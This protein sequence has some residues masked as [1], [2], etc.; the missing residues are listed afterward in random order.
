MYNVIFYKLCIAIVNVIISFKEAHK[1]NPE[2]QLTL[3]VPVLQL[4]CHSHNRILKPGEIM[5]FLYLSD[6]NIWTCGHSHTQFKLWK[7]EIHCN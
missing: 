3:K 7:L 6:T 4:Q 1:F 5:Q 2:L